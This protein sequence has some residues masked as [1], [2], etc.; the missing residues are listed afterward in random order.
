MPTPGQELASIPFADML[1]GPLIACINAQAAAA[2]STVNFIKEVGFKKLPGEQ[3]PE[4]AQ[5]SDPIYVGFKYPKEVSPFQP[6]VPE[7]LT[8]SLTNGGSG[9]TG[10]PTVSF[11]GGG[12]T[13]AAATATAVGGVVTS[14]TLTNPGTGYTSKPTIVFTGG[15]GTGAAGEATFTPATPAMPAQ[16]QQMIMEV[17]LISLLPIPY[18]RIEDVTIDFNAKI[19]SIEYQK[20]DTSL[21]I[22]A[23]LEL[24]AGNKKGSVKLNVSVAYQRNTQQGSSVA[25]TYSM[26][27]HIKAVQDEMP[28]G[29]ARILDILESNI[30][31]QPANAPKAITA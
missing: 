19:D 30:K 28:A 27:V 11:T 18:L 7:S 3:D 21:K 26:A 12:G 6:A 23:A 16:F 2:M 29:M 25:R 15:G 20:I 22:D 24:K 1:G 10:D 17:A 31:S 8:L 13:G 14:L 4:A 9:Y 5:T